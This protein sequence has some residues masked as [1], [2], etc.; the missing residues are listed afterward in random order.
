V[1]SQ[2]GA[3]VTP[4]F[5]SVKDAARI[6]AISDWSMYQLLDD[7]L[8]ESRYFGRRR[9]VVLPSLHAYAETLPTSPGDEES[10]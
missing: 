7:G 1:Q 8:V 10:A 4:I 9:L 2:T 6:L 3:S 5:V